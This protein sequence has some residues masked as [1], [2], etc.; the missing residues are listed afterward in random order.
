GELV[1]RDELRSTLWQNDTF[2]DFET[3]LNTAIKRLRETLGDSAENPTLIETVP[4]RGYKFIA[5][6]ELRPIHDNGRTQSRSRRVG[7]LSIAV[8]AGVV[9]LVLISL[10]AWGKRPQPSVANLVRITN[11]GRAMNAPVTDGVHLYFIEGTPWST[12]S[13]IV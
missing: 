6:V 8:M 1:S 2:V 3:G 4:R 12:G 11:D 10:A 5:A 13:R 9:A 7:L